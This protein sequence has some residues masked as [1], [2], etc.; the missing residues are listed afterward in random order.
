MNIPKM[1]T[2]DRG[3]FES[4]DQV[5][6]PIDKDKCTVQNVDYIYYKSQWYKAKL[7]DNEESYDIDCPIFTR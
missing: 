5:Y 6:Y 2:Q 4:L 3:S 7:Q 1:K